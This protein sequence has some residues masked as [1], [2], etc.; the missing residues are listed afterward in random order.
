MFPM[1]HI[2]FAG[3]VIENPS[4]FTFLGSVYPDIVISEKIGRDET[5]YNT[6]RIYDYFKICDSNMRDFALG[7]VS[8]GVDMKG[9]DYYSDENY[10]SLNR[11]YCFDRA[12]LI[13]DDVVACCRIPREWGLWKA[14]NFIEMAFEIYLCRLE[15]HLKDLL[16]ST[17]E[18]EQVLKDVC[19]GLEDYYQIPSQ[20]FFESFNNYKEAAFYEKVDEYTMVRKYGMFL[21]KRHG[22][23]NMNVE[24]GIR[25]IQKAIQVITPEADR[26]M[27]YTT[28]E[29]KPVIDG[30]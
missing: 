21:F 28:G 22:I 10:D 16:E 25:V 24:D 30:L 20:S 19:R 5:H 26:F 29:V 6:G 14:H 17:F 8:H 12:K 27:E 11:G 18:N 3:K 2:Y 9:M 4:L 1:C 23:G 15:G 7:A 13:E